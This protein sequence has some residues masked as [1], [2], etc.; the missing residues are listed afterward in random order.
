MLYQL[1]G[2]HNVPLARSKRHA[3]QIALVHGQLQVGLLPQTL[4]GRGEDWEA[5]D[6]RRSPGGV[7]QSFLPPSGRT[8]GYKLSD[9]L[10]AHSR[11]IGNA[12]ESH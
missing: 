5:E 11:A 3:I 4:G 10:V 8:D 12:E 2:N 1:F 9:R 7:R 6:T